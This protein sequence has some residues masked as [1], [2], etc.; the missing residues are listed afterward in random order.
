MVSFAIRAVEGRLGSA[1]PAQ[2]PGPGSGS[3]NGHEE[4]GQLPLATAVASPGTVE[5]RARRGIRSGGRAGGEISL[6][7]RCLQ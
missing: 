1:G 5:R 6:G 2:G 7:L 4:Q 3:L